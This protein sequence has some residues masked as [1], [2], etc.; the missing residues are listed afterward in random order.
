MII[1]QLN[2]FPYG[3]N[4]ALIGLN[5]MHNA[6]Q[7]QRSITLYKSLPLNPTLKSCSVL[8]DPSCARRSAGISVALT[9]PIAMYLLLAISGA[10]AAVAQ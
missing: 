9:P 7:L 6:E 2:T 1:T 8:F 4:L 5:T 10:S 3:Q